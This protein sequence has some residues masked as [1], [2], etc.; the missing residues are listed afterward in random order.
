M[1]ITKISQKRLTT[2]YY[3]SE[4]IFEFV[5]RSC[6]GCRPGKAVAN[7]KPEPEFGDRAFFLKLLFLHRRVSVFFNPSTR[8]S[9][10]RG[11]K[12]RS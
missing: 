6:V 3:Q 4:F 10:K 12:T 7:I 2:L 5:W 8:S 1:K 11:R 9:V